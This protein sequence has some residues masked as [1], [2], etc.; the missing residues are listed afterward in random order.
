MI[1]QVIFADFVKGLLTCILSWA[2][3]NLLCRL[4]ENLRTYSGPHCPF[5]TFIVSELIISAGSSIVFVRE[6]DVTHWGDFLNGEKCFTYLE[7][8]GVKPL[9]WALFMSTKEAIW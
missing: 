1:T 8:L 2:W 5:W 9:L 7:F 6:S 4:R 3:N